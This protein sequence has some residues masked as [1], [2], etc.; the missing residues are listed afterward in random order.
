MCIRDSCKSKFVKYD[1]IATKSFA[2]D[3]THT[4]IGLN[5][6]VNFATTILS[7]LFVHDDIL[8]R[9][10]TSIRAHFEYV[11]FLSNWA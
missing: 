10:M 3:H 7:R 6:V 9:S 11:H 5:R 2:V 1:I 8:S 4:H